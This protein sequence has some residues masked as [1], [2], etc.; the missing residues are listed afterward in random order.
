MLHVFLHRVKYWTKVDMTKNQLDPLTLTVEE[1]QRQLSSGQTSSGALVK[2]YRDQISKHNGR[3]KAVWSLAADA[4]LDKRI[5]ELDQERSQGRI[6][7]PLH[8]VPVLIK[9][10]LSQLPQISSTKLRQ[11]NIATDADYNLDT[12]AGS[13]ALVGAV[14]PESADLVKHVWASGK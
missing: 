4:V 9:V 1:I 10:L 2:L 6:R 5:S 3:L 12:T 13:L 7:G 11:D 14:A 8:G